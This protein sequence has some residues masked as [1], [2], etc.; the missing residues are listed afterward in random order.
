MAIHEII[1]A[2]I[3]ILGTFYAVFTLATHAKELHSLTK[4]KQ[5]EN[6]IKILAERK[7]LL[8][9]LKDLIVFP[10]NHVPLFRLRITMTSRYQFDEA[11]AL[12]H[13]RDKDT[14]NK[15]YETVLG[16]FREKR[17]DIEIYFP[18]QIDLYDT[19]LNNAST[20]MSS[21]E[22]HKSG[23]VKSWDLELEKQTFEDFDLF[24][25]AANKSLEI[26]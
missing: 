24:I 7:D 1:L 17:A 23:V 8:N 4:S 10:R 5:V 16:L 11:Q 3:G 22:T 2:A 21:I 12:L 19:F 18:K 14:T 20:L 15:W 6:A 9:S 25:S 13:G 26:I